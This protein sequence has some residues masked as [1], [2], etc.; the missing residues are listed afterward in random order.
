M[1][2]HSKRLWVSYNIQLRQ[3]KSMDIWRIQSLLA[4]VGWVYSMSTQFRLDLTFDH[5]DTL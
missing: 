4:R 1:T 3:L 5:A 2:T